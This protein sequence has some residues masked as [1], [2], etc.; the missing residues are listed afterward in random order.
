MKCDSPMLTPPCPH[1]P[2]LFYR[3]AFFIW[4]EVYTQEELLHPVRLRQRRESKFFF[5]AC[6][7]YSCA[8]TANRTAA[9]AR[10]ALIQHNVTSLA[11]RKG[12]AERNAAA[13]RALS[14][15]R[16]RVNVPPHTVARSRSRHVFC[17]RRR[18]SISSRAAPPEIA[19]ESSDREKV[20]L[21][22][23]GNKK[24]NKPIKQHGGPRGLDFRACQLGRKG[25]ETEF[26]FF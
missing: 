1:R 17:L 4:I 12:R 20:Q 6:V 16:A 14:L 19:R 2:P 7:A 3:H 22:V 11:Q 18:Q 5:F 25:S 10:R 13:A 21:T 23:Q 26:E 24:I 15:P 9:L 8:F